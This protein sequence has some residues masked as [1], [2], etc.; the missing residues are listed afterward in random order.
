MKFENHVKLR[1]YVG[2]KVIWG[3]AVTGREYC[4][5]QIITSDSKEYESDIVSE[6]RNFIRIMVFNQRKR[7]LVDELKEA[8]LKRGMHIE[9][10][11]RL[12]T[13]KT[14]YRGMAVLQLFVQI[15]SFEILSNSNN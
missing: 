10:E 7:K 3:T 6:S 11:G 13:S 4:S 14:D 5:F 9:V 15:K 1:G 12:Q 8:G 2:D